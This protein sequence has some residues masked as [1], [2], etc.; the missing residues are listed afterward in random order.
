LHHQDAADVL[1]VAHVLIALTDVGERVYRAED[2]PHDL[3]FPLGKTG[4][5]Q[6]GLESVIG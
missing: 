5:G 2:A 1:A 3:L 4:Q 6:L